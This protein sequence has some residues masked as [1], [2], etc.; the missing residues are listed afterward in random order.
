MKYRDAHLALLRFHGDDMS[1]FKWEELKQEDPD[2]LKKCAMNAML[3]ESRRKLSWIWMATTQG[4]KGDARMYDGKW[5][6]FYFIR[7][8]LI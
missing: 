2:T 3:G 6:L 7:W 8:L 1:S 4:A 5:V